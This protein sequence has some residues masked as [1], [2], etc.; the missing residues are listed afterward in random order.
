L[1]EKV[2]TLRVKRYRP[3]IDKKPFFQDYQVTVRKDTVVLDAL[4]NIKDDMDGTL[5]YRWSCR[6]GVCGSCGAN[7]NGV[8]VLTCATFISKLNSEIVVVEPLSFFP[9]IR[10][11]AVDM[12][13]FMYK[14]REVKPYIVRREERPVDAGEFLQKPHE[15]ELFKQTSMCI[16]CM[17]CY[18]ACPVYGMEKDFIGP[19][20]L[21]L[22]YRYQMDSR[23]EGRD[24]RMEAIVGP[25]GI[26]SCHDVG[27][28]SA[29]CPKG[30]DP[31]GAIQ[32]LKAMGARYIIKSILTGGPRRK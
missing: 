27:Y 28:C 17:L 6:M 29:V 25:E 9:V 16:N 19:A 1:Q 12:S 21:A 18:S 24:E 22:A 26:W 13:D 20:A 2:V 11:L 10:D 14:L 7:V 8:P 32:T 4:N 23:D 30:V 5:T 3:G 31:E 15:L